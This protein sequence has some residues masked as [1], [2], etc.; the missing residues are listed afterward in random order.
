[1]GV[2]EKI[3]GPFLYSAQEALV[4]IENRLAAKDPRLSDQARQAWLEVSTSARAVAT[5]GPR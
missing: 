2:G 1:M 4:A 3:A 5:R